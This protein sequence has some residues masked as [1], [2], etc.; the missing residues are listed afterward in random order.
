V[1][2]RERRKRFGVSNKPSVRVNGRL[3]GG[4][5]GIVGKNDGWRLFETGKR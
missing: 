5:G 3:E 2:Q 4:D 1:I